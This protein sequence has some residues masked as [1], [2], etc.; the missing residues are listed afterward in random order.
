MKIKK[1]I[2][3]NFKCFQGYYKLDLSTNENNIILIGGLNGTGKTSIVEAINLCIYGRL[4]NHIIS[5][6]DSYSKFIKYS[7][8]RNSETVNDNS[9][10]IEMEIE[11]EDDYDNSTLILRRQWNIENK[12]INESFTIYKEGRPL[13]Y[14][15]KEYLQDYLL[16]L[17]PHYISEYFFFDGEKI[18]ELTIGN[19]AEKILNEAVRKIIGLESYEILDEDLSRLLSRIISKNAKRNKLYNELSEKQN[20]KDRLE[21]KIKTYQKKILDNN[22]TLL[23]IKNKKIN[24]E[25]KLKKEAGIFATEQQNNQLIIQDLNKELYNINEEIKLI[26]GEY[27]PFIIT[28]DLCKKLLYQLKLEKKV[29]ETIIKEIMLN[30]IKERINNNPKIKKNKD[31]Y[32]LINDEFYNIK[33]EIIE[34]KEKDILHDLSPTDMEYINSVIENS[35]KK[36]NEKLLSLL[37]SKQKLESKIHIINKKMQTVP[38]DKYIEQYINEISSI[39]SQIEILKESKLKY[40]REIVSDEQIINK[41][42]KEINELKGNIVMAKTDDHKVD[43]LNRIQY[44]IEEYSELLIKSR[45]NELQN[46]ITEMYNNLSNKDD[47]VK[48]INFNKNDLSLQLFDYNDKKINKELISEGEKEILVLSILW[49]LSC[50][51]DKNIP[52]IVD[53]PLARLDQKHVDNILKHFFPTASK[54]VIIFSHDREIDSKGYDKILKKIHKSYTLTFDEKNK[55][56][57]GYSW[58]K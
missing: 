53:S 55:I 18:K 38:H 23:E 8:N 3:N 19:N 21:S 45:L 54:Q 46:K 11:I 40:E 24:L 47:M 9:Y 20:Q 14:I 13:D 58:G 42:V 27:L 25:A 44:V 39:K 5:K 34:Y 49:G 28:S 29:H 37:K 43:L 15:P 57:E 36:Y 22:N 35:I 7:K 51:S 4:Y 33:N 1:L 41:I 2:I 16:S 17:I 56:F 32:K 10:Y 6:K 12:K 52:L 31:I 30:D 26:C 50:L 48:D